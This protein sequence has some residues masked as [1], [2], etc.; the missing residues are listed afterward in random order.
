MF[1]ARNITGIALATLIVIPLSGCGLSRSAPDDPD[2]ER[3]GVLGYTPLGHHLVAAE[4]QQ[5]QIEMLM[6]QQQQQIANALGQMAQ[7]TPNSPQVGK[8][9]KSADQAAQQLAQNNIPAAIGEMKQARDEVLKESLPSR[10]LRQAR[11]SLFSAVPCGTPRPTPNIAHDYP[12][13]I[14]VDARIAVA[15]TVALLRPL[16][17]AEGG[18]PPAHRRAVRRVHGHRA[19]GVRHAVLSSV[20]AAPDCELSGDLR[21]LRDAA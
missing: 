4:N 16:G 8:A 13:E 17:I 1:K 10:P 7:A 2:A 6:T 20:L 12:L 9:Q 14:E 5:Q 3:L 19:R 21:V 11:F 15:S 18:R